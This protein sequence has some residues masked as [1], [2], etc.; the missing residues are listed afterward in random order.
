MFKLGWGHP[1]RHADL[2]RR[3]HPN[4]DRLAVEQRRVTTSGLQRMTSSVAIVQDHPQAVLSLVSRDNLRLDRHA[5]TNDVH[6]AVAIE[7]Q[8]RPG[9]LF[10]GVEQRGVADQRV[11]DRLGPT[12]ATLAVGERSQ[13]VDVGKDEA[14]LVLAAEP[15]GTVG[16]GTVRPLSP[17]EL[18][19]KLKL[20][21]GGEERV[22]VLTHVR[23]QPAV[24]ICRTL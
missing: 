21:G 14:W 4:R 9:V 19:A 22:V 2:R 23:N 10:Q 12:G 11:L 3:R 17:E 13:D 5:S 6:Q 24:L 16:L 8:Q 7:G 15:H 1:K 18:I 20:P